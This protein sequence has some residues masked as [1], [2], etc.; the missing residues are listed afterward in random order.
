MDRGRS[1]TGI[2]ERVKAG[3]TAAK[4]RGV[5]LGRPPKLK[6]RTPEIMKLKG[7]GLGIRA[8][9]RSL[10]MPVSSVH[11]LVEWA[12]RGAALLAERSA[13]VATGV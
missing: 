4:A 1:S 8:I 10:G 13:D 9:S 5:K 2:R 6:A 7:Q 11:S 12:E 3:V